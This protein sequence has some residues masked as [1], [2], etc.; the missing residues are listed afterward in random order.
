[1]KSNYYLPSG[2][3]LSSSSSSS[4]MSISSGLACLESSANSLREVSLLHRKM[5]TII[6]NF[7]LHNI[8]VYL[9]KKKKTTN[10]TKRIFSL[11]LGLSRSAS[12]ASCCAF[13]SSIFMSSIP[14]WPGARSDTRHKNNL[15]E[16][17]NNHHFMNSNR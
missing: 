3:W 10:R 8:Y 2:P 7:I 15:L 11:G 1:M 16:R 14:I 9:C 17:T 12:A 4:S 13:C 5:Q 6:S